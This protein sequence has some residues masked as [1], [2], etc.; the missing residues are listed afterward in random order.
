MIRLSGLVNLKSVG[1]AS[2]APRSVNEEELK[3]K[4]NKLDA[5]KDGK[6]SK[7]DFAL[8][9]KKKKNKKGKI[10][11]TTETTMNEYSPYGTIPTTTTPTTTLPPRTTKPI[12][13]QTAEE[14]QHVQEV[15]RKANAKA[16]TLTI[17][18]IIKIL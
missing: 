1:L 10:T 13:N 17:I 9:K 12:E 15:F 18:P 11:S 5:N 6:I 16:I 3:G 14:Q 8:L 4:Q 7:A 2:M